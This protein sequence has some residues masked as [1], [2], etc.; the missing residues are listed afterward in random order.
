M[1][2]TGGQSARGLPV[3][4]G[5]GSGACA[6][7][8]GSRLP[9]RTATRGGL[10]GSRPSGRP[11]RGAA[12]AR[13]CA[14]PA[15]KRARPLSQAPPGQPP[16]LPSRDPTRP[17]SPTLTLYLS[18]YCAISVLYSYS[19]STPCS[20][21]NKVHP[22]C[23][24]FTLPTS[25]FSHAPPPPPSL[26]PHL[27]QPLLPNRPQFIPHPHTFSVHKRCITLPVFHFHMC[28]MPFWHMV[29]H[30]LLTSYQHPAAPP[31]VPLSLNLCYTCV[32]FPET[33]P[34]IRSNPTTRARRR[35]EAR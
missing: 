19:S 15:R 30:K 8:R 20:T 29:S 11:G 22:A 34:P 23:P 14:P 27:P 33:Y 10:R 13:P 9:A 5:S 17:A 12:G 26:L 7:L 25:R 21:W 2:G 4:R 32:V 3:R 28:S 31:S 24:F 35:S 18:A 6:A 1:A 16:V